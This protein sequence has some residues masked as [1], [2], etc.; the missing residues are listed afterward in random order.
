MLALLPAVAYALI[1][2]ALARPGPGQDWRNRAL[3]AALIWGATLTL[4]T[5][6]LSRFGQLSA[7]PLAL[8]WGSV[9]V[10][11]AVAVPPAVLGRPT[12]PRRLRLDWPEIG[13]L[14]PVAL[15]IILTGLIAALG[16]PNNV[17]ALA[18][19]LARVAHWIQDGSVAFYPTS[20]VIQL[21][22]PNF[23][24]HPGPRPPS[25]TSSCSAATI[26]WQIC[27]SGS[28]WSVAWLGSP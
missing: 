8:A 26:D 9:V 1:S 6:V 19:H 25:C 12:L 17:D 27:L 14:A 20:S 18:Y 22:Y 7:A 10:A 3:I 13:L 28:A 23:T 24:I 2:A 15:T 4:I 11:A 21:Y 16:W 5:E